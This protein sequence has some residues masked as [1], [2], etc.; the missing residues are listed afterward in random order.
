MYFA[1]QRHALYRQAAVQSCSSKLPLLPKAA[2]QS[3]SPK[4]FPKAIPCNYFPEVMPKTPPQNECPKLLCCKCVPQS[5]SPP[6]RLPE[7]AP[8]VAP[9]S[10]PPK[11]RSKAGR[12]SCSPRLKF[13]KAF[14]RSC[15]AKLLL[16]PKH[17]P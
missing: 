6:K 1:L 9:D 8:K 7:T 16:L 14:T 17:A 4:L 13:F 12:Q 11:L 10:C 3:F 2:P 15:R 5:A